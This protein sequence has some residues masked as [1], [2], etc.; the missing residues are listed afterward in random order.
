MILT[1]IIVKEIK[2][3]KYLLYKIILA[4]IYIINILCY[5]LKI[6]RYIGTYIINL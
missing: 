4:V 6:E 5:E 1:I 2:I 3:D